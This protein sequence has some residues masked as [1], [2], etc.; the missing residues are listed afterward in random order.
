[1]ILNCN[2]EE[3]QALR[4]GAGLVLSGAPLGMASARY[5]AAGRG[6]VERL[7]PLLDGSIS[8]RNLVELESIS[9]A[10]SLIASTLRH[11]LEATVLEYHPAHEEAVTLYFEHAHV[12]VALDRLERMG[13][14]MRGLIELMTGDSPTADSAG[15]V[16]FP[17]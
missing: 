10:V 5:P 12:L 17:D 2:F 13:D 16:S 9:G 3:L 14:E 15:S 1:M 8:V 6:D 7:V 4:S 11:R